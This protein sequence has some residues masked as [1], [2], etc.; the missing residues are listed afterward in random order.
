MS[1]IRVNFVRLAVSLL[2]VVGIAAVVSGQLAARTTIPNHDHA[3]QTVVN[4]R[5]AVDP[6]GCHYDHRGFRHCH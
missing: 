2:L 3:D 4:H 1:T 5:G 6:W